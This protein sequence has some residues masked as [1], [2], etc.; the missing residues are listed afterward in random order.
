MVMSQLRQSCAP[1]L[2]PAAVRAAALVIVLGATISVA[3]REAEALPSFSRQT[4]QPCAACHVDFPQLTPYGRLFKLYGYTQ[5][6]GTVSRYIPP[7]MMTKASASPST[8]ESGWVPPISFQTIASFTN[9]TASQPTAGTQSWVR[10]NNNIEFQEASV[11]YGGAITEHLGLMMQGDYIN[12]VTAGSTAG[13]GAPGFGVATHEFNWDMLDLRYAD[14]ATFGNN[15]GLVYGVTV[16][17]QPG[18]QDVWNTIP[19]WNFPFVSSTLA[20]TPTAK[21]LIEGAFTQRVMGAG[22]YVFVNEL[23]YLEASG[24]GT[25]SPSAQNGLGIDPTGAPGLI[26]GIAPYFRVAVEP[27]WAANWLE[28][29]AFAFL[30]EVNPQPWIFGGINPL[31]GLAAGFDRYTDIGVDSQYQYK[32]GDYWITLR[33][34]YIHEDQ[35]LDASSLLL[36]TNANDQLNSLRATASLTYGTDNLVVLTGGYFK[37]WGTPDAA[38]YGPGTAANSITNSPNSDGFIVELAYI[39][40]G[41]SS[42]KIWPWANARIGIQYILYNTFNGTST[43]FD[44]MGTNASDNNAVYLYA[45]FTW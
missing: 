4:G 23:V 45:Q 21:T 18:V 28:V 30:P 14:V 40:Y 9:T 31:T 43:N 37:V 32:G 35:K 13:P 22:A 24:Y 38:L 33:G 36:G 11:W 12:P 17:N 20:P 6:R 44:G 27:H 19:A 39:P 41:L 2:L 16:N 34:T 15:F 1:T 7:I 10:P 26:D 29:G 5:S 25:L 42:P 8:A 3:P